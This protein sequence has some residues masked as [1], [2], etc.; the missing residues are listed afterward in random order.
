MYSKDE[1][2]LQVGRQIQDFI[3]FL[4][5][6]DTLGAKGWQRQRTGQRGYV[7]RFKR[8][9]EFYALLTPEGN[10]PAS[11][12]GHGPHPVTR[13]ACL[14]LLCHA[15]LA[16]NAPSQ[17]CDDHMA[18]QSRSLHSEKANLAPD[19]QGIVYLL[20]KDPHTLRLRDL[21]CSYSAACTAQIA[22]RLSWTTHKHV[23]SIL[24]S[25]LS[26]ERLG[27]KDG[28]LSPRLIKAI[29]QEALSFQPPA[30][31]QAPGAFTIEV[32]DIY[33]A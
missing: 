11:L 13:M 12:G 26:A 1:D 32:R 10:E 25:C 15:L 17:A 14:L 30:N 28:L 31:P 7:N 8:G 18:Q 29:W 24:L 2:S 33:P 9:G 19:L 20:L 6:V 22:K 16:L 27:Y 4:R 23:A 3:A 21:N 5:C